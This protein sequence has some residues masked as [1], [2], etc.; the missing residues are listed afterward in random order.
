[1]L[2]DRYGF[3]RGHV[4]A[5]RKIYLFGGGVRQEI[6]ES[7]IFFFPKFRSKTSLSDITSVKQDITDV[8][9]ETAIKHYIARKH[10]TCGDLKV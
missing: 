4:L 6:R 3:P 8:K 10:K 9:A 7:I 2:S 5:R 1:M